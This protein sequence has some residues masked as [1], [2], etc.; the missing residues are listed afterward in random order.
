[1][2]GSGTVLVAALSAA[3]LTACAGPTS[4]RTGAADLGAAPVPRTPVLAGCPQQGSGSALPGLT[5]PC[6]QQGPAV[7][8]ARLGGAPVLVNLWASWCVPCQREMPA[9][10]RTYAAHGAQ[11]RFL[12]VDSEDEPNSAKDFLAAVGVHYPQVVDNRG[13]LLHRIGGS[14]LPVT[15]VLDARGRLVFSHR[16]QL[17]ERDLQAALAAA[18][19]PAARH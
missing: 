1:M 11:L 15:L 14:G 18:G 6:L 8:P 3:L 2:A 5:L 13:E 17:R 16:G 9:L 19:I 12:G 4:R 7:D 10:Q